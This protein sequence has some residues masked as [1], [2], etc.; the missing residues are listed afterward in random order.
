VI[1]HFT[2]D[3]LDAVRARYP[4]FWVCE[5]VLRD[6]AALVAVPATP[7][8]AQ[9]AVAGAEVIVGALIDG[10]SFRPRRD[11]RGSGRAQH[12]GDAALLPGFDEIPA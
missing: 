4:G 11:E 8:N 7:E 12:P 5:V 6:S 3:E 9:R 10:C 2:A 1:R